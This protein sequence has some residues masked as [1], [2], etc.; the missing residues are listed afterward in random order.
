MINGQLEGFFQ[1]KRGLRQGDPMSP[2]L[3]ALCMEFF[4]RSLATL[5]F[6]NR[7]KYHPKCKQLKISHILF[8]DNVLLFCKA[9]I[10]SVIALNDKLNEFFQV[11]GLRPRKAVFMWLVFQK[12]NRSKSVKCLIWSVAPYH[13]ST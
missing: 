10:H 1:G 5:E 4:S 7:F 6:D 11:S 2:Y 8:A 3:F 12:L 13:L 9:D